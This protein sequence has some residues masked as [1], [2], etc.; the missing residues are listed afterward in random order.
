MRP[1]FLEVLEYIEEGEP[2]FSIP[3]P[4]R[5]ASIYR[6]SHFYL[7]EFPQS[8]QPLAE[9]PRPHTELGA[10]IENDFESADDGYQGRPLPQLQRPSF[11]QPGPDTDTEDEA[12]RRNNFDPSRPP[13]P[14]Q[15]SSSL[16]GRVGEA[17]AAGLTSILA[18]GAGG[19]GQAAQNF[20]FRNAT[21]A[22]NAVEQRVF[23]Q[24]I[25]R[26]T[27]AQRV[28][29]QAGQR[30]QEIQTPA[31]QDIEQFVAEQAAAET[32]DITPLLAETG[33]AAGEA[34]GVGA[35]DLLGGAVHTVLAPEV[36]IPA[37]IG[38]A[39]GAGGALAAGVGRSEASTQTA[40]ASGSRIAAIAAG[41]SAFP[42]ARN[43]G[44][45]GGA[46]VGGLGAATL[47]L[48]L[49]AYEGARYMLG[50]N[51]GDGSSSDQA[52]DIRTLNNMQQGAPQQ[53]ISLRQPRAQPRAQQPMVSRMDAE[54]DDAPMAQ[55]Q[56]QPR[57]QVRSR[58][59]Q[60]PFGLGGGSLPRTPP[61]SG[62]DASG[63][64][65]PQRQARPEPSFNELRREALIRDPELA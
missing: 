43:L 34:A 53:Q 61:L 14:G 16:S 22:A 13:D 4:N 64:Q 60:R 33:A 27:D 40:P 37:A 55:Q 38:L 44:R 2:S 23:P 7:D 57:P 3:L 41:A 15:P 54:S 42:T 19:V 18:A 50:G 26:P 32:A 9:N 24:I 5:N 46:A 48:G 17:A 47:G 28:I 65:R 11:L 8:T 56:S 49:G 63:R 12:Y 35:L 30:A 6:S 29:E 45:A 52:P 25:G 20:S 10:A 21:R 1:R 31:A 36:A 51:V 62:S 59:I 58:P 39:A